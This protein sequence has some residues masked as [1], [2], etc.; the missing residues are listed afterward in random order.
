MWKAQKGPN[1]P[2]TIPHVVAEKATDQAGHH[3]SS[4][5]AVIHEV[6]GFSVAADL[7]VPLFSP[8]PYIP[9]ENKLVTIKDTA[10]RDVGVDFALAHSLTLPRDRKNLEGIKTP[11][12]GIIS[13]QCLITVNI[14]FFSCVYK[15]FVPLY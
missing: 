2:P 10:V 15:Y 11:E 9:M 4:P 1:P 8:K 7:H 13:F 3:N 6:G 12:L 5:P 14:L